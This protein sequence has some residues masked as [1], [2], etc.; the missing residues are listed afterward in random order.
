MV[1]PCKIMTY[2]RLRD[3]ETS[4][5]NS[6]GFLTVEDFAWLLFV[7]HVEGKKKRMLEVDASKCS[8][9]WQIYSEIKRQRVLRVNWQI[10]LVPLDFGAP[11][12]S[13]CQHP[14][15]PQQNIALWWDDWWCITKTLVAS[16]WRISS[17]KSH[18]VVKVNNSSGPCALNKISSFNLRLKN[19]LDVIKNWKC[20]PPTHTT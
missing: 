17:A 11:L 2:V 19:K 13:W 16:K 5:R 1:R 8:S 20:V 18:I 4:S 10:W 14:K 3:S 12:R 9:H 7:L 6:T 15:V